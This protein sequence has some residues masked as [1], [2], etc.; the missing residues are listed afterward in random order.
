[1]GV[2]RTTIHTVSAKKKLESSRST[3]SLAPH[4]GI[5]EQFLQSNRS[6]ASLKP[7]GEGGTVILNRLAERIAIPEDFIMRPE[8]SAMQAHVKPNLLKQTKHETAQKPFISGNVIRIRGCTSWGKRIRQTPIVNGTTSSILP[9]IRDAVKAGNLAKASMDQINKLSF[10]PVER[11]PFLERV[12]KDDKRVEILC[13]KLKVLSS[14]KKVALNH[15]KIYPSVNGVVSHADFIKMCR[16]LNIP[17]KFAD[18][19]IYGKQGVVDDVGNVNLLALGVY[20]SKKVSKMRVYRENIDNFSS[21]VFNKTILSVGAKSGIEV[22]P[23][24]LGAVVG[25][26]QNPSSPVATNLC[27]RSYNKEGLVAK[28]PPWKR[29]L[30]SARWGDEH[31]RSTFELIRGREG[32]ALYQE[33]AFQIELPTL[34]LLDHARKQKHMKAKAVVLR[35][36]QAAVEQRKTYD[37]LTRAQKDR[38]NLEIKL[39]QHDRYDK[40]VNAERVRRATLWTDSGKKFDGDLPPRLQHRKHQYEQHIDDGSYTTAMGRRNGV[41]KQEWQRVFKRCVS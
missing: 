40:F 26:I 17:S 33:D 38:Q 13:S 20:H 9:P 30:G 12:R 39:R 6:C 21:P 36:N 11:N 19:L 2:G 10:V 3:T 4:V 5:K 22:S 27:K 1:M 29:D 28:S 7:Y 41:S 24:L 14:N 25:G 8:E 31:Y 18:Q 15:M 34:S 37:H 35:G 32:S 16:T 23:G